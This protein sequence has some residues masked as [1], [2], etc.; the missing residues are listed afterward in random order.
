M[1]NYQPALVETRRTRH[2]QESLHRSARKRVHAESQKSTFGK[3]AFSPKQVVRQLG[4]LRPL[5]TG[6]PLD[7]RL[8]SSF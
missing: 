3:S 7:L 2:G 5:D 1:G 8:A 4:A 6:F